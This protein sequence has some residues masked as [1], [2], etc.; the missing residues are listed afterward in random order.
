MDNI[1]ST[2]ACFFL[3]PTKAKPPITMNNSAH[4]IKHPAVICA[5]KSSFKKPVHHHRPKSVQ[6]LKVRKK[7]RAKILETLK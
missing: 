4:E 6:L 5:R 2:R 7:E 3:L 1:P